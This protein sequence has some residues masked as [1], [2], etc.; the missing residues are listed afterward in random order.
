M[1]ADLS[2]P[3]IP[4]EDNMENKV[5]KKKKRKHDVLENMPEADLEVP[6][7]SG[8]SV[9]AALKPTQRFQ[10]LKDY[11]DFEQHKPEVPKSSTMAEV[12][13]VTVKDSQS[14]PLSLGLRGAMNRLDAQ[15]KN[16]ENVNGK[17]FKAPDKR[18][19]LPVP[20]ALN[21]KYKLHPG[22]F[23][24]TEAILPATF[25]SVK[26]TGKNQRDNVLL[27]MKLHKSWE[28]MVRQSISVASFIDYNLTCLQQ[29]LR[30][31]SESIPTTFKYVEQKV[32]TLE[33][34]S[35]ILRQQNHHSQYAAKEIASGLSDLNNLLV[36][37]LGTNTL[38]RRDMYLNNLKNGS[39]EETFS[40]LRYGSIQ[41]EFIFDP[42]TLKQA[43]MEIDNQSERSYGNHK[44]NMTAAQMQQVSIIAA[45]IQAAQK[46]SGNTKPPQ[47]RNWS[48]QED[49]PSSN[50]K[51]HKKKETK[52]FS[53]SNKTKKNV[54]AK[55]DR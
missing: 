42:P 23:Q 7:F 18:P 20:T 40:N 13:E 36:A 54:K 46:K 1:R 34:A 6:L 3:S 17:T 10:L 51:R 44:D 14:L 43:K 25:Q 15:L 47:K 49:P 4:N 29:M 35:K 12:P 55:K 48:A 37:Q 9:P 38:S 24:Q 33:Q 31:Q 26:Y 52:P 21:N 27:P 19:N 28:V 50:A 11:M 32:Y 8:D 53:S 41:S 16:L 22:Q 5:K 2:S 45:A 39:K 30:R